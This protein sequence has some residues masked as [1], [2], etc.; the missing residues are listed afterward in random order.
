[1]PVISD[2]EKVLANARE[3]HGDVK[4]VFWDED[5]S[6]TMNPLKDIVWWNGEFNELYVGG[7]HTNGEF[8]KH[9]SL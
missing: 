8:D 6:V 3:S 9:I 1:M 7:F 4:L 5:W 2:L